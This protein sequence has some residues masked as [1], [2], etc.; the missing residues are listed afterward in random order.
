M[1]RYSRRN[2]RANSALP[3]YDN[4][5]FDLGHPASRAQAD[6]DEY[7]IDSD[8]GS[9]PHQGPYRS[10]P[11]PAS[12][13]WDPDHPAAPDHLIEDYGLLNKFLELSKTCYT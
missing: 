6:I 9:T 13:G 8:F 7:G 3:G 5:G 12:V 2:R 11:P 10:G 1:A 4:L